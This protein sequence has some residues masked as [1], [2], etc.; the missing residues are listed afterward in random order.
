MKPMEEE[1]IY[2]DNPLDNQ[3]FVEFHQN[4]IDKEK[5]L[6]L[7]EQGANINATSDSGWNIL[8]HYIH[9]REDRWGNESGCINLSEIQFLL[10]LGIDIDFA[11]DSCFGEL[12][13]LCI[14]IMAGDFET[15]EFLLKAGA[16][17]NC[18]C[19]T[20]G[21]LLD[22]AYDELGTY[23]PK[24]GKIWTKEDHAIFGLFKDYGAEY[25]ENLDVPQSIPK[26]YELRKL[27]TQKEL[28]SFG[29]E[30]AKYKTYKPLF[31]NLYENKMIY[32]GTEGT[33]LIQVKSIEITLKGISLKAVPI[34]KLRNGYS[35]NSPSKMDELDRFISWDP[36]TWSSSDTCIHIPRVSCS[37]WFAERTIRKVEKLVAESRFDEINDVLY[38]GHAKNRKQNEKKETRKILREIEIL[39]IFGK[40]WNSFNPYHIKDYLHK[41][42]VYESAWVDGQIKGSVAV[43]K[44]L[45]DR[46]EVFSKKFEKGTAKAEI[47]YLKNKNS[48]RDSIFG[49]CKPCLVVTQRE[50]FNDTKA[51][52]EIELMGDEIVKIDVNKL[53]EDGVN[54]LI[55]NPFK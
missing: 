18:I 45:K 39:E 3:L 12:N 33:Y 15:T 49:K 5:I 43:W 13:C 23:E 44:H 52:V 40:C 11:C 38:E 1:H 6:S 29:N 8:W 9:D 20:R 54:R 28:Q 50:K 51:I 7:I 41:D 22:F 21:S 36:M 55:E 32:R 19:E 10:D 31:E 14:T 48:R 37:L 42:M 35:R 26:T 27:D 47:G 25:I 30:E 34:S 2:N 24:K 46:H 4:E 17:P 53:P 16:N